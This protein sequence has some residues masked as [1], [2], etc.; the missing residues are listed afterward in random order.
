MTK[1]VKNNGVD[2]RFGCA[3]TLS[4]IFEKPQLFQ[5]LIH[6]ADQSG[7]TGRQM[8]FSQ[9]KFEILL[10]DFLSTYGANDVNR[11]KA[12][13]SLEN[14]KQANLLVD[15]DKGNKRLTFSDS[16]IE[17]I[18]L[19]DERLI[20]EL[21]SVEYRGMLEE[22]R[23][24]RD[25]LKETGLKEVD[26][27]YYLDIR[28]AMFNH[29][30]KMRTAIRTNEVKFNTLSQKLADLS[31]G[32]TVDEVEYAK[33]KREMFSS[34]SKLYERHIKPT[35]EFLDKSIK[36]EGGNLFDVLSDIIEIFSARMEDEF[37]E[38]LTFSMLNLSNSYKPIEKIA[39][40][41]KKFLS[42]SRNN[43]RAYNAFEQINARIGDAVKELKNASMRS[44]TLTRNQ[45]LVDVF[46]FYRNAD[47]TTNIRA[48]NTILWSENKS[49]FDNMQL[50][51]QQLLALK[52]VAQTLELIEVESIENTKKVKKEL[53]DKARANQLIQLVGKMELRETSD[54]YALLHERLKTTL[55]Q[56][57]YFDLNVAKRGLEARAK[58]CGLQLVSTGFRETLENKGKNYTYN[59]RKLKTNF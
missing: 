49:F 6:Q 7:D 2:K 26:E 51:V 11:Y 24:L 56:Y 38:E 59:V 52:G 53:S 48:Q 1:K 4:K 37:V 42:I 14:L 47:G 58:E 44:K 45:D 28:S 30:R 3:E 31:T 5:S 40:E 16:F 46:D 17:L 41:V 39:R 12:I 13:Y 19:S 29:L 18:R 35:V 33:C 15:W 23:R 8:G 32:I 50:E 20:R 21:T 54:V 57:S 22:T 55:P 43:A 25:R 27:E 10:N 34:A 9:T 36:V